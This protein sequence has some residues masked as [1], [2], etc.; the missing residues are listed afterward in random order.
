CAIQIKR[1]STV[2]AFSAFTIEILATKHKGYILIQSKIY[3][4]HLK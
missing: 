1:S 3:C 4:L 2:R